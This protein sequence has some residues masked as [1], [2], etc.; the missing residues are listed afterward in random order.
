MA[1]PFSYSYRN[2]WNRRL[3]TS[4]TVAGMALVV[5]VFAAILMLAEGLQK[6]LTTTGSWDN[7]VVIRKG[8]TSEVMSGIERDKSSLL[9]TLPQIAP[10]PGGRNLLARELVV[11][12]CLRKEQSGSPSNVTIRGIGD[13]SLDLRPQVR[14]VEGRRPRPGAYEIMAGSGI[15]RQFDSVRLNRSLRFALRDWRVVG[16][17]DAGGTGFSSEIWGDVDTLM[18]AFRRPVYSSV[19]FRLRS[20]GDFEA[21]RSRIEGDPR[22]SLEAK[23]EVRYYEEQSEIMAKFLRIL[24]YSLTVIF[25]IGAVMGAMITMYSAVATRT[26]EIGTLRALGFRRRE[27]L[28]AFLMEALFLGLFGGLAGLVPASFMQLLT[29]STMNFQSFAEL[30]F[31]FALTPGIALGS[32]GFALLMGLV[33]GVFPA[34]RAARMK[35]TEALREA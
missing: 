12:I 9:E 25:S 14:I 16:I 31:R 28:A 34:A 7:V 23:R 8:S 26:S 35:I 10:G 11:L 1:I 30:S 6:T 13:L 4:L 5:F 20:P 15:A 22:L 32:V 27:I 24:G 2:L 29:V 19:V 18:Q 33:G 21:V 17:F 3:T